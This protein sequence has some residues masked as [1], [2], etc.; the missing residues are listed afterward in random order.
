[1]FAQVCIYT[2][3]YIHKYMHVCMCAFVCVCVCIGSVLSVV[4]H[5]LYYLITDICCLVSSHAER[6]AV[7]VAADFYLARNG[8]PS[9]LEPTEFDKPI[10][11]HKFV[12][13]KQF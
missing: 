5:Y 10:K 8:I 6:V 11:E 1:M 12:L 7:F 13:R 9:S 2:S 3:L 4:Y